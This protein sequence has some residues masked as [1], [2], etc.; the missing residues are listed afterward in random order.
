LDE[1]R[2]RNGGRVVTEEAQHASHGGWR[3]S[4]AFEEGANVAWPEP[5]QTWRHLDREESAGLGQAV[6]GGPVNGEEVGHVLH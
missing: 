3:T 2:Q 6:D 5:K 1:G 4:A